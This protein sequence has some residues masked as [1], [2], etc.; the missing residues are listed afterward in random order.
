M[1]AAKAAS[2]GA[3]EPAA[4]AAAAAEVAAWAE[5]ARLATAGADAAVEVAE[6]ELEGYDPSAY[7]WSAFL[8]T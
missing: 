8:E 6:E 1:Q 3:A 5:A 7:D 2:V 4:A